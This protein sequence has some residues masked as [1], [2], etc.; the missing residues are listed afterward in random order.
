MNF[1]APFWRGLAWAEAHPYLIAAALAAVLIARLLLTNGGRGSRGPSPTRRPGQN[2]VG[3]TGHGFATAYEQR[4]QLGLGNARKEVR[5]LRPSLR[6]PQPEGSRLPAWCY[7][8]WHIAAKEAGTYIGRAARKLFSTFSDTTLV[9]APP[10]TGKTA[11]LAGT[12]IEAPGCVLTTSTKIDSYRAIYPLRSRIGKVWIINPE[13]LG[14][15][16]SNFAWSFVDGCE[17]AEVA[18]QT[19]GYLL[20]GSNVTKGTEASAYWEGSN[21]KVGRGM[22]LA[23]ARNGRGPL[24]VA[25]WVKNPADR[26][27]LELLEADPHAPAGWVDD[28][29]QVYDSEATKTTDNIFSTLALVFDFLSDEQTARAC[30]PTEAR[31]Q[32]DLAAL[33]DSRDTVVLIAND[34]PTGGL[35]PMFTALTGRFFDLACAKAANMP[36]ERLDPPLVM[37]LDEVPLICAVPLDRWC[38]DSAGRGI[39]IHHAGQGWSQYIARWGEHAAQTIWTTANVKLFLNGI[40][41]PKTLHDA[42]ILAGKHPNVTEDITTGSDGKRTKRL[43]VGQDVPTMNEGDIR[44][45]REWTALLIYRNMLPTVVKITPVWKRPA[46]RKLARADQRRAAARRLQRQPKPDDRGAATQD[47]NREDERIAA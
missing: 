13:D 23:A 37:V 31:P 42:S 2:L 38:A 11:Q 25:R 44:M 16:A 21:A 7:R 4:K 17:K 36:K 40:S 15:V 10:Q 27:P 39:V 29:R 47:A 22:L 20:S 5:R 35:G 28:L 24:T 3:R 46:V 43:S 12:I 34:R 9:I 8:R 14:N 19:M 33:L 41:D 18:I 6:H 32:L 26:E 1:N 45:L 30:I